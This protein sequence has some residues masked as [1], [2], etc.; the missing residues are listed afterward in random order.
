MANYARGKGDRRPEDYCFELI[1]YSHT[2][3][4]VTVRPGRD[5]Y[6]LFAQYQC[7]MHD[8]SSAS[9]ARC[10]IYAN[11]KEQSGFAR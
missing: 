2:T 9:L 4:P 6:K 1:G 5:F 8:L 10:F 11:L 3:N 7:H